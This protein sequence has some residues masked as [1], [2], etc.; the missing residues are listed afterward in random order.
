MDNEVLMDVLW[1]VV[2]FFINPLLIVA[3]VAAVLLGYFRVKRERQSFRVR[4]LPGLTELKQIL[5]DSWPYAIV[6]SILI[7]GIGLSVDAGWLVLF[8]LASLIGLLSF[9]YKLTS[10]IYFAAIAFFT[11]YLL[12]YLEAGFVYRGWTASGV[13]LF[14]DL[15]VTV[16][17]IAGMLL[18]TEGILIHRYANRNAS[19]FLTQTRGLRAGVVKAKR[20]VVATDF[21]SSAR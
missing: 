19:P 13:D 11:I 18:F 20:F 3:L 9:N 16:P 12:D 2:L 14:G 6:L 21:V 4:L 17:I 7:S 5:V 15:A 10:P 1:A 8:C